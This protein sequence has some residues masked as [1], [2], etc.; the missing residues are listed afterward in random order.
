MRKRDKEKGIGIFIKK[1]IHSINHITLKELESDQRYEKDNQ[2]GCVPPK[3]S[4]VKQEKLGH[5]GSGGS[6]NERTE[7]E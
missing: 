5:V 4:E 1:S 2:L 7:K 3:K 6:K